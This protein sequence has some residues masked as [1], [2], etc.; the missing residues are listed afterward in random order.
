MRAYFY[1][2]ASGFVACVILAAFIVT[3][4]LPKRNEAAH[5]TSRTISGEPAKVKST[6]T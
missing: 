6:E 1:G 5:A 2:V 4:T 3:C